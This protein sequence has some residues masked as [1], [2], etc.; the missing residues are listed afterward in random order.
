MDIVSQATLTSHKA[1]TATWACQDFN[2]KP[3][4][5]GTYRVYFEIA[6]DDVTGPNRFEQFTKGSAPATLTPADNNNFKAIG[7]S[8]QP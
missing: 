7:I 6:D 8:Y 5:D 1:H 3:V 2:G 4:P